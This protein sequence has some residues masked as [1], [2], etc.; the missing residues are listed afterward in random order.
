[1]KFYFSVTIILLGIFWSL[2]GCGSDTNVSK[3]SYQG[4][5]S[6]EIFAHHIGESNLSYNKRY[7]DKLGNLTKE[8]EYRLERGDTVFYSQRIIRGGKEYWI[9]KI[10][11]QEIE[12][13][14]S[15]TDPYTNRSV[16]TITRTP[17][18]T[19]AIFQDMEVKQLDDAVFEETLAP[20]SVA[21]SFQ[22][23]RFYVFSD[24]LLREQFFR[25]GV[26]THE[27][28]YKYDDYG[29]PLYKALKTKIDPKVYTYENLSFDDDMHW[30]KRNIYLNK[31]LFAVEEQTIYKP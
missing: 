16:Q 1:M 12:R 24:L 8:I 14:Y 15:G 27:V 6:I 25:D 10:D 9:Q 13:I 26:M 4:I 23:R 7:F 22:M 31:E 19:H 28:I 20:I 18:S 11:N 21:D 5:D 29:N 30:T 3:V 2:M 17:S